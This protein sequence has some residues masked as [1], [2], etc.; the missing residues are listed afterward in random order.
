MMARNILERLSIGQEKQSKKAE[1]TFSSWTNSADVAGHP[2]H[3]TGPH[4]PRALARAVDSL[5]QRQTWATVSLILETLY[6]VR[7]FRCVAIV[8]SRY[9]SARLDAVRGLAVC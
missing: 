6:P 9:D 1:L 2:V 8:A 4:I 3:Q 5:S 7:R